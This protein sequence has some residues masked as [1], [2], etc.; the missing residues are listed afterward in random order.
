MGVR[1]CPWSREMVLR[2]DIELK[3]THKVSGA[4]GWGRNYTPV[5]CGV[6]SSRELKE[7]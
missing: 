5:G 6:S 1:R 7:H 2:K 4:I 3:P